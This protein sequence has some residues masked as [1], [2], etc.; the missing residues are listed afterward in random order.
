M[1][2]KLKLPWYIIACDVDNTLTDSLESYGNPL[3]AMVS[4]VNTISS[5][6]NTRVMIWSGR[7]KE[8]ADLMIQRL[9]LHRCFGADK[10]DET[11][12]SY[13]KPHIAI[14]DVHSFKLGDINLIVRKHV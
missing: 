11:T 6:E 1:N 14:D 4:L 5:M 9:G 7:G 10:L 3:P 13:G 2:R 12:W 8:Y